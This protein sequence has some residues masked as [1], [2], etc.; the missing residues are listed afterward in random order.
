MLTLWVLKDAEF[1]VD[2]KNINLACNKMHL[3]KVIPKKRAELGLF[4][5]KSQFSMCNV[6]HTVKI[7][8]ENRWKIRNVI[9]K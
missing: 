5:N 6:V 8:C 1:Y 4:L 3:K 2:F 9:L 7:L